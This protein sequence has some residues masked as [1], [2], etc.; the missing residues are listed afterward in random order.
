MKCVIYNIPTRFFGKVLS[1][2]QSTALSK[3]IITFQELLQR[4]RTFLLYSKADEPRRERERIKTNPEW[5]MV[6]PSGSSLDQMPWLETWQMGKAASVWRL[7]LSLESTADVCPWVER[8]TNEKQFPAREERA[9]ANHSCFQ[10][11]ECYLKFKHHWSNLCN[12]SLK[13][14]HKVLCRPFRAL[15]LFLSPIRG[16]PARTASP[17]LSPAASPKRPTSTTVEMGKPLEGSG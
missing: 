1:K 11:K 2:T 4:K 12:T 6:T 17:L 16:S 3:S 9:E 10:K 5:E 13:G 15:H 8:Q 7:G 14:D